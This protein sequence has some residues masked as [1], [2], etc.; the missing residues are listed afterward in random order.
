MTDP[1]AMLTNLFDQFTRSAWRWECQTDYAVDHPALDRWKRGLPRETAGKQRWL[2]Y[3]RK[4][5]GAGRRFDRVRVYTE[6]LND[7][8]SWMIEF[9]HEN[10]EAGEDIRW[11]PQR[12]ARDLDMPTYD[13]YL[14]DDVRLAIMRFD[15]NT[16]LLAHLDTTDDPDAVEQH[17]IYRDLVWPRAVRHADLVV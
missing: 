4:I 8:L 16:K 3:I 15:P 17:R 5:T 2:D 11:L 12:V 14:F 6:P 9:T 7:Y 1:N 10:V 13:F